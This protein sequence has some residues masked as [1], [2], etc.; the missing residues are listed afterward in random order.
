MPQAR[1]YKLMSEHLARL[2]LVPRGILLLPS[3]R[4]EFGEP[5][6]DLISTA[7]AESKQPLE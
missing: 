5:V 4:F 2:A 1:D 7:V 3:S 6:S